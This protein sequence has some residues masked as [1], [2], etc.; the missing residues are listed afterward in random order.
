MLRVRFLVLGSVAAG[1]ACGAWAGP[2]IADLITAPGAKNF[3]AGGAATPLA[4]S[5]LGMPGQC[6]NI[7]RTR[8][9]GYQC[10]LLRAFSLQP[11]L[12]LPTATVGW[13]NKGITITATTTPA[14]PTPT[15]SAT[16][17]GIVV[18]K[19]MTIG[20]GNGMP[21]GTI[22]SLPNRPKNDVAINGDFESLTSSSGTFTGFADQFQHSTT[23]V[24]GILAYGLNTAPANPGGA[25]GSASDPIYLAAGSSS[26]VYPYSVEIDVDLNSNL[27]NLQGGVEYYAVDSN[28]YPGDSNSFTTDDPGQ[29][30]DFTLNSNNADNTLWTLSFSYNGVTSSSSSINV[31]FELN[32]ASEFGFSSNEISALKCTGASNMTMCI[33]GAID[34]ELAGALTSD[35]LGGWKEDVTL[36][37][38]CGPT[39]PSPCVTYTPTPTA[40]LTALTGTPE[41][42]Y[43]EGVN[44]GVIDV[45]EP[46]ASGLLLVSLAASGILYR[47]RSRVT[48]TEA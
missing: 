1:L 39:A 11:G 23:G 40:T 2:A 29:I 7:S 10:T 18:A 26:N 48:S 31:D 41:V 13:V 34:A 30:D 25:A 17:N 24:R 19:G 5:G 38:E 16:A 8:G 36:F 33:D 14:L 22:F 9:P 43:E 35:A 15:S 3:A 37:S 45:P 20:G 47:R 4:S 21:T 27:S 44:A 6:N 32:T 28:T 42:E 12:G 46:P